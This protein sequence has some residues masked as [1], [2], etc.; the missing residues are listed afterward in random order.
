MPAEAPADAEAAHHW[1]Q[2]TAP[3]APQWGRV[4]AGPS[5]VALPSWQQVVR[6]WEAQEQAQE[7]PRQQALAPSGLLGDGAP[8]GGEFQVNTYTTSNQR[9]PSIAT[10]ADGNYVVVWESNGSSGTDSDSYS[11]HGQRYNASGVAQ[12][13]AFQVNTYTTGRQDR[14]AVAMDAD[15]DF[16]V[17]WESTGSSGTDT[18]V[19]SIQGQRFNASGV[20]Q[21]SPFQVNTYTTNAQQNP[22]VAMDADGDF[23][24]VW[25]SVGS[26]GTDTDGNSIQGQRYNASGVAQGSQFQVNTYT[27]SQQRFPDVATDAD[28]DFVVVWQSNGS[29]GTDTNSYSIHGLRYNASGVAQGSPFQV[30]TYTSGV[31]RFPAIAMDADGDFVVAWDSAGSSGTDTDG[32]SIQGQRYNASG[33]AQGSQ[34]QVNTY[35]TDD[36]ETPS[37]AIDD[38]GDFA[39]MWRSTGSSGTDTSQTS[40]QGQ[41]YDATGTA[42]GGEFQVNTYTTLGQISPAVAMDAD[43]DFIAAWGSR[44][45]DG[46]DTSN[47]SVQGQRYEANKIVVGSAFQVNTYTTNKQGVLDVAA[48]ADGDFVV[49]WD[50]NGS[51]GTDTNSYSVHGQRYNAA[52]VAQGSQFQINTYTTN[53]QDSPSV[54]MDADG[55]FVVVW[56]SNGSSGTD[57]NSYSVHGQRYNADGSTAGSQFQINTYTTGRQ[58]SPSVAM[59]ADGDFVVVWRS[60]GSSG[61][62]T[63]SYSIQGQRYNA[64]GSTA[65][66]QFQVNTY[67]TNRQEN[68]AVAIDADGDFVVAWSSG[69]FSASGSSGTDTDRESIQGQRYN[70]SGVAQGSQF[71]VNTYT[72]SR[73]VQPSVAMDAGGDFV[74]I[75]SSNGS[76][77]TDTDSYSVQGQRY[78]ASGVAQGSA[79][80]V[81]T[82]TT[83]RQDRP[84]VAMD[85]DG[86]FVVI[87]ESTGSSGT[88]TDVDSIQGQRFNASGV[89]QGSPFQVNTYTTNA[90]TLPAVA[91]DADGDFT[92]AWNSDGSSGTDTDSY[93][94]QGQRYTQDA[95][96]TITG[97]ANWHLLATPFSDL[98]FDDLFGSLW[99]QGFT[100]S[101]NPSATDDNVFTY[102]EATAGNR[103]LGF[104]ALSDQAATMTPGQGYAI[105]V[106][107][108]D[109]ADT[110]GTQGGF[111]KT[112]SVNGTDNAAPFAFDGGSGRYGL[113][114]TDSGNAREDGWNLIGN[115]FPAP[116]DWD[117]GATKTNL[118]ASVYVWDAASGQY[119]TWNGSA[120]TLTG[121]I[122]PQFQGFFV[123]ASAASPALTFTAET[124]TRSG[125]GLHKGDT[126]PAT[127]P[128]VQLRLH[129]LADG[130]EAHAFVMLAPAAALGRD[131]LDTALLSPL[132]SDRVLLYSHLPG[133]GTG[134][135]VVNALPNP[136]TEAQVLPLVVETSATG[137]VELEVLK[138]DAFAD[139]LL[140]V[141][142]TETGARF[143]VEPGATYRFDLAAGSG[144]G[145]TDERG[146]PRSIAHRSQASARFQLTIRPQSVGVDEVSELPQRLTL[147]QNY[148]NPFNP[149]T[150]IRYGL[151]EAGEVRLVVYDVLGREVARLV[152]GHQGAGWQAVQ[153]QAGDAASG[154]YLYR[155]EVNGQSQQGTMLLVK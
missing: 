114:F 33:V 20:A 28:G 43:G 18:D 50:S 99:T 104:T 143:A 123:R 45:S 53:R 44:G 51:S 14:P 76:S 46:T 152:D 17:I 94:I 29:S 35:T 136:L 59:D 5:V 117:E 151:P 122:I 58:D 100:G 101:D 1:R 118:E 73:Q 128:V 38:D 116:I 64:D 42:K 83:G 87:W 34:F 103:D 41:C 54:A 121:G 108:D 90:Q 110:G 6:R 9:S 124:M 55:D 147:D 4:S 141:E 148:P 48:D 81:N 22:A 105:F 153:W 129:R 137:E 134:S 8:L 49:V 135:F 32:D 84:A 60:N 71:Q 131:V 70:A 74:V 120:G 62:D 19:D 92:A 97:S 133:A 113:S 86:D 11:I 79:F 80:Q 102:D 142:D 66:S 3:T 61:T 10:D 119:Q 144:K 126:S 85:A 115:P 12:G 146:L 67:T 13:S 57:T 149:S 91:M 138:L 139:Y 68:P 21:G 82:Y 25:Q 93:S 27:T 154:L 88:D 77:G 24:V 69:S 56:R 130:K 78:N 112:L 132:T 72:T 109:D 75:W 36:Q 23:V 96:P 2:A 95:D 98:S 106:F 52:G 39:I 107:E 150:T 30:N 111:P 7:A 15:G 40:I 16:V 89:A 127:V 145:Q 140:E 31:Q 125:D 37:V 65:G 47:Y 26:S 63:D 155:L